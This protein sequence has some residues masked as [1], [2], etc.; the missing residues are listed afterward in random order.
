MSRYYPRAAVSFLNLGGEGGNGGGEVTIDENTELQVKPI[1]TFIDP[2]SK[3]RVSQPAN[4]TDTDFEYGLQESKWETLERVNNIPTFFSRPGD[5]DIVVS[6]VTAVQNSTQITV[7]TP[8]A[9][10]LIVGSPIIV[11]G[12]TSNSAEGAY[13]ITQV[14]NSTTFVYQAKRTQSFPGLNEGATFLINQDETVLYPGKLYQGTQY[15][16][17]NLSTIQTDGADPSS[18]TVTTKTPHGFVPTTKFILSN[19]VG[20][21]TFKFDASQ[22]QPDI[23]STTSVSN[24]LNSRDPDITESYEK[25]AS[26]NS[27]WK[28][29]F[30]VFV[31]ASDV[32]FNQNIIF[33]QNHG[34]D[35]GDAV[36]YIAPRFIADASF[37]AVDCSIGGLS[38]YSIYWVEKI[39]NDEFS[40]SSAEIYKRNIGTIVGLSHPG[41]TEFAPHHFC[42]VYRLDAADA[43]LD[44][45]RTAFPILDVDNADEIRIFST[46]SGIAS[47]PGS[48]SLNNYNS[49]QYVN[50]FMNHRVTGPTDTSIGSSAGTGL[51]TVTANASFINISTE[52]LTANEFLSDQNLVTGDEVYYLAGRNGSIGGLSDGGTYFIRKVGDT[53]FQLFTTKATAI[54]NTL[55]NRINLTSTGPLANETHRFIKFRRWFRLSTNSSL[56]S[57]AD[58]TSTTVTGTTWMV[59]VTSLQSTA[60]DSFYIEDH[61]L[62]TNDVVLASIT[63]DASTVTTER[64][65]NSLNMNTTHKFAVEGR[66]QINSSTETFTVSNTAVNNVDFVRNGSLVKYEVKPDIAFFNMNTGINTTT[67]VITTFGD[68]KDAW[69]RSFITGESVIFAGRCMQMRLDLDNTDLVNDRFRTNNTLGYRNGQAVTISAQGT[70]DLLN[71]GVNNSTTYFLRIVTTNSEIS[72]HTTE[73]GAIANTG[74]VD[75]TTQGTGIGV[76]QPVDLGSPTGLD[77]ESSYFI[78]V[79]SNTTFTLHSSS[80]G[81]IANTDR[82]DITTVGSGNGFIRQSQQSALGGLVSGS[83]YY[84]RRDSNAAF[85]LFN[86]RVNAFTTA[87]TTGIVDLSAPVLSAGNALHQFTVLEHGQVLGSV[88]TAATSRVN[89]ESTYQ[90]QNGQQV[91]YIA[92]PSGATTQIQGLTFGGKY[93]VRVISTTVIS[94]HRSAS[95]ALSDTDRVAISGLGNGYLIATAAPSGLGDGVNYIIERVDSNRVRFRE[96]LSSGTFQTLDPSAY[97]YA[98]VTLVRRSAIGNSETVFI[99][100]HGLSEQTEL[101]YNSG[102]NDEIDIYSEFLNGYTDTTLENNSDYYVISPSQDRFRLSRSAEIITKSLTA[103]PSTID[104]TAFVFT[105]P[106]HGF[107]TGDTVIYESS[108]PVSGLAGGAVYYVLRMRDSNFSFANNAWN[109]STEQTPSFTHGLASGAVVPVVYRTGTFQGDTVT[110]TAAGGLTLERL[111]WIKTVGA[112]TSAVEFYNNESDAIAGTGKINITGQGTGTAYLERSNRFALFYQNSDLFDGSLMTIDPLTPANSIASDV[113]IP[114]LSF[115]TGSTHNFRKANIIDF[116]LAGSGEQ[117]LSNVAPNAVD[118]IYEIQD[119]TGGDSSVQ[120]R[121]S[122]TNAILSPRNLTFNPKEQ[123]TLQYGLIR[124]VGHSLYTGAPIIYN[125]ALEYSFDHQE[126]G[127]GVTGPTIDLDNNLFVDNTIGAATGTEVLYISDD[128]LGGLESDQTYY[129]GNV[130]ASSFALYATQGD[131]ET[132]TDRIDITA[133][134]FDEESAPLPLT[135]TATFFVPST[136]E[137]MGGLSNGQ[138]YFVVRKSVDYIG[139]ASSFENSQTDTT[140]TLT[141][142]G[143]DDNHILRTFNVAAE[144]PALGTVATTNGSNLIVGSGTNFFNLFKIGDVFKIA[145][146]ETDAVTTIT[147]G[148][149][150]FERLHTVS[151]V[152]T[153]TNIVTLAGAHQTANGTPVLYTSSGSEIAPLVSGSVY[154]TGNGSGATFRVYSTKELAVTG[155]SASAID[156]TN[157]GSGTRTFVQINQIVTSNISGGAGAAHNLVT[158]D[159][160]KYAS[161]NVAGGLEDGRIYYVDVTSSSGFLLHSTYSSALSGG[162]EHA[163]AVELTSVPT[164]TGTFTTR[165]PGTVFES[166]ISGIK[167]ATSLLLENNIPATN[168][169]VASTPIGTQSGLNYLIGTSLFVKGDAFALHRPFDGGVELTPSLNPDSM[170]TRQTRKYFRYQ[171]GKGIQVS[172]G[173]NF[174]APTQIDYYTRDAGTGLA[175]VKTRFPNRATSGLVLNVVN[176]VDSQIP[177]DIV[178]QQTNSI[179]DTAENSFLFNQ[180]HGLKDGM[181][182]FYDANA[183]IGGLQEGVRYFVGLDASDPNNKFKLY[184]SIT[185]ALTK[186]IDGVIEITS[187]PAG[188][189]SATFEIEN[190]WN[191]QY[192][193]QNIIDERTFTIQLTSIPPSSY[194]QGFSQYTPNSWTNSFLRAGMFDDQNGMYF[195]FDGS[196]LYVCRRSSTNQISG[197][198]TATFSSGEITGTNTL[199]TSQ[200]EKG[201]KIVIRGQTYKI[202]NI[203][204]DTT[205]HIQPPYSGVS[206][207]NIIVSKIQ[208]LRIP[209]SEWNLDP[210]NGTGNSG[211]NLDLT[212]MQMAYMDYSW[213]GAGKV[214]FGFKGVDGFVRYFHEIVHNNRET[215]AYL[216]SGN[217]PTRYEVENVGVPSY[218]PTIAH[219]GTS[220]IMDGGFEDDKGYL[221]NAPG[222]QI[223]YTNSAIDLTFVGS[224]L[225]TSTTAR[226]FDPDFNSFTNRRFITA[227]SYAAVQNIQNN[228]LITGTGLPAGT[229]TVGNP[230]P[231]TGTT[232]LVF[233][234]TVPTT[235][236]SSAT[237]TYG[238]TGV[239]D[240]IPGRFPLV[241]LRLGPSVDNGFVGRIGTR[242][243]INRMQVKLKQVG[244]ITTHDIEVKLLLNAD[245][246]NID[247]EGVTKP[248]LSQIIKHQKNDSVSGGVE[249]YTFRVNGSST[250]TQSIASSLTLTLED[251]FE[252][253]NSILGGDG[254]YPDGPDLLTVTAEVISS[255]GIS[256]LVPLRVSGRLSWSESQA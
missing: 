242:D 14:L 195:E 68:V 231:S 197:T 61:G 38:S 53:S 22:I 131:A 213:Y 40:L 217:L 124:N 151:S 240:A 31:N 170:V 25:Y 255:A 169:D 41:N 8:E 208:E 101:N 224:I 167:S 52:I 72:L 98:R 60:R 186:N 173:I 51:L 171:S 55:A 9:H 219:W 162:G 201:D 210:A 46:S 109:T 58:V 82:V 139:L 44:S 129:V 175:T 179:V 174:N 85:R 243:I 6:S 18:L 177:N 121:L 11:Q 156:I 116:K 180:G 200:L 161:A 144:V 86:S 234:D 54:N 157:A 106:D 215:E 78:R 70:Y 16:L 76:I 103:G 73:A 196:D 32:R 108:F 80:A 4:L 69:L 126:P 105:I 239:A 122:P 211:F 204:S 30:G 84:I 138:T 206:K 79:L 95:G 189:T 160:V 120:F 107:K 67:D 36:M 33:A 241:S 212:K 141:S 166:P 184:N 225:S 154:Y 21:K 57:S 5:E 164:G 190:P 143:E 48:R 221:F 118:G 249:I 191:G 19:T 112:T 182:V 203:S 37:G 102:I 43:G 15:K 26:T 256:S 135:G 99:T 251:L 193:I 187:I 220:V 244:I 232:G 218:S 12:L 194:A 49:G 165:N 247:F 168:T 2:V 222:N 93:F 123:V 253:G 245:V 94:L 252:L 133:Q 13:V 176:A 236:S 28:G 223:Q 88:N 147:Q 75:I 233:I 65:S 23:L 152:D 71:N 188:T 113:R 140:I 153:G 238:T 3:I 77:S 111:Y 198:V 87:S 39:S 115:Q 185:N 226:V 104:T 91:E 207:S 50:F 183:L 35:H 27:D 228:T 110:G 74:R 117:E 229:R 205:L 155:N 237:Y 150:S 149:Q 145:V 159:A 24:V 119:V 92:L 42:K 230:Q 7:V 83:T 192:S 142:Y 128:P 134:E 114:L 100:G 178:F 64:Y 89:V 10:N 81:A 47:N 59:P 254:I 96:R 29:K 202:V 248:S 62:E 163:T 216:R 1:E 137:P 209:Q 250:A 246:D 199:F 181:A 34:F 17:D 146:P 63:T 56:T 20:G 172:F 132:D 125:P 97:Q 45:V 235:T 66:T 148:N 214:R 130:S 90:Y 136:F 127:V 227:T 158:G